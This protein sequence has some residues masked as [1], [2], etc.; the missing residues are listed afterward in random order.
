MNVRD[1]LVNIERFLYARQ[2]DTSAAAICDAA[3]WSDS[4]RCG[5]TVGIGWSFSGRVASRGFR[6]DGG[7]RW[8]ALTARC[9]AVFTSLLLFS[10]DSHL[11]RP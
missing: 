9:P 4:L 2:R 3:G 8:F 1:A 6:E 7:N 10:A 5:E 11:A